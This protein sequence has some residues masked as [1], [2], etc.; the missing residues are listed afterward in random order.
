MKKFLLLAMLAAPTWAQY[1]EVWVS[2]GQNMLGN[3]GIG[4]DAQVGGS[5]DDYKLTDGFR[6]GFRMTLN[7]DSIFGHEMQYAY[8]RT[9][10]QFGTGATA[11]KLGMAVHMGG[12]N[13]LVYANH[14]GNRVRPFATGG[15]GFN[16]FTPPGSSATQ[17]GGSNKFGLN[18]G[19]G[20]KARLAGMYAVRFDF[21]Q[22][23]SPKPNFGLAL[24]DGWIRFNEISGGFGFVF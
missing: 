9:P 14:E 21:R 18:Y 11:Q 15:V 13:Y 22:Y 6:F 10:L 8:N 16:N 5:K 12:Y 19:G 2:V 17:G 24:A 3:S 4:T 23:R 20:V 7:G 1:G